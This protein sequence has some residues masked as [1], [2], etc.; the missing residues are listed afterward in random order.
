MMLKYIYINYIHC[1]IAT[2]QNF[3]HLCLFNQFEYY[4]LNIVLDAYI[5][6]WNTLEIKMNNKLCL[7][8]TYA[9]VFNKVQQN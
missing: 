6:I 4:V 9:L 8:G 3:M 1:K 5:G 2:N 7:H